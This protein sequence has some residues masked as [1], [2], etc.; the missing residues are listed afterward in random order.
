M[1]ES[2]ADLDNLELAYLDDNLLKVKDYKNLVVENII[3]KN[4]RGDAVSVSDSDN[5]TIKNCEF[6]NLSVWSAYVTNSKNVVLEENVIRDT[7]SGITIKGGDYTNLTPSDNI[8]RNNLMY[9]IG[10]YT[11]YGRNIPVVLDDV[12]SKVMGNTIYNLPFHAI[13]YFGNDNLIAYN[14]IYDVCNETNDVSAIYSNGKYYHRGSQVCYN[15]IHD[16]DHSY[17]FADYV[18]EKEWS[19]IGVQCVYLDN[20]LNGQYVHHNIFKNVLCGVNVNCGQ[21][22]TVTENT[23]IDIENEGVNLTSYA[24]GDKERVESFTED[25][26][27]VENNEAYSKYEGLVNPTETEY[28]GRPAYN[29]VTDNILVNSEVVFTS[30][31]IKY[32]GVVENNTEVSVDEYGFAVDCENPQILSQKNFDVNNF[33]IEEKVNKNINVNVVQKNNSYTFD[34]EDS[35]KI[36]SYELYIENEKVAE[37]SDSVTLKTLPSYGEVSIKVVPVSKG[38][39]VKSNAFMCK[40]NILQERIG[41]FVFLDEKGKETNAQNTRIIQGN[42]NNIRGVA[43]PFVAVYKNDRMV[44]FKEIDGN[45]TIDVSGDEIK[46][47]IWNMKTLVPYGDF[48]GKDGK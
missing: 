32:F 25:F 14:E 33:G 46:I 39:K 17:N 28:A 43:T 26:L 16:I 5:I 4:S 10:W 18:P 11:G 38:L 21:Y 3:F 45:D 29:K 8:I 9:N 2:P 47:M 44:L 30:E 48:I 42:I 41:E 1:P 13:N 20:A 34:V 24:S 6:Y 27:A 22:N 31:N 36:G 12:G 7:A 35:L 19:F 40:E 37:F 15:Y 23:I